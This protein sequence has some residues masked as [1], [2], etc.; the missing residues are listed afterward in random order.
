MG[1]HNWYVVLGGDWVWQPF[2]KVAKVMERPFYMNPRKAVEFGVA[3]K[4][5]NS[6]SARHYLSVTTHYSKLHQQLS[7]GTHSRH[8]VSFKKSLLICLLTSWW[9]QLEWFLRRLSC[10]NFWQH[11]YPWYLELLLEISSLLD[12]FVGSRSCGEGKRRWPRHWRQKNGIRG[13]V[14][15]WLS[16]QQHMVHLHQ[17]AHQFREPQ[18]YNEF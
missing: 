11:K 10:T 6:L 17:Q 5:V 15:V 12:L 14:S 2:E 7:W 9:A 8:L 16:G 18:L 1:I 13:Q 4:V 3:D